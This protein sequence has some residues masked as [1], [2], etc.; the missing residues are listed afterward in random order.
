MSLDVV[1]LWLLKGDFSDIDTYNFVNL[2]NDA[3]FKNMSKFSSTG[4]GQG[5]QQLAYQ[6]RTFFEDTA[7]EQEFTTN[8]FCGPYISE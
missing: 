3:S 1:V 2:T 8:I 5:D 4:L 7:A 6:T